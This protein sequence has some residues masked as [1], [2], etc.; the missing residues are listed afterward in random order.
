MKISFLFGAGAEIIYGMPHGGT[1]ALDIFK[2]DSAPAKEKFKDNCGMINVTSEYAMS[3]LPE[4]FQNKN[5]WSFGKTAYD[6]IIQDTLINNRN[7]IIESINKLD[8][9]A[10][11]LSEY[12][13]IIQII[14]S[15]LG[16]KIDKLNGSGMFSFSESFI[17]G[18]KLLQSNYFVA[19]LYL[20]KE[21]KIY[22]IYR[23][24]LEKIVIYIFQLLF[25][26]LGE[27]VIQKINQELL[28]S[29]G[30]GK[31]DN[32]SQGIGN[33]VKI[34]YRNAG[35]D[36]LSFV[37]GKDSDIDQSED[38]KIIQF[39]KDILRKI[40]SEAISYKTLIDSNWQYLYTPKKDWAKFCKI[41]IFLH[42]VR[43][44]IHIPNFGEGCTEGYYQDLAKALAPENRRF[45]LGCVTTT[46]YNHYIE[47][48]IGETVFFLNGDTENY[49]DPYLNDI[50]LLEELDLSHILVPLLFTQSGTKPMTS[51]TVSKR[52]VDAYD[53]FK[54]SDMICVVGFG[55]NDDD[56]HINCLVRRLIDKDNKQ[57]VVI[58]PPCDE[59]G[60]RDII[61]S[62]LRV[63]KKDNI[64]VMGVDGNRLSKSILWIDKLLSY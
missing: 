6:S 32:L 10:M 9:Y 15:R 12:H 38:G 34:D 14:E 8:E 48:V 56:E 16:K 40:Y 33:L 55:F 43:E 59:A 5:V 64:R 58:C 22:N 7:K 30:N 2:S 61:S 37:L 21:D 49:Y 36:G 18:E 11:A 47:K 20:L 50:G 19:M 52:Y 3:W 28:V 31:L 41:S 13:S 53:K 62:Q 39:C 25:G 27:D 35:L 42:Q 29:N 51:I 46:N 1:F 63:T 54:K 23:D 60:K 26:A 24:S 57:L 4:N 44:Y 17:A 45:D